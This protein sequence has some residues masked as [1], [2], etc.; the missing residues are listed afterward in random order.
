MLKIKHGFVGQR[1]VV[2]PFNIIENALNNPL[3]SDLA[4]HSI[5]YFPKA[6]NHF[7]SRKNGCGEYLLIYCIKGEG[8]YSL[9]GK[10]HIV[11]ANCFFILPAEQAHEYG[12]SDHAPWYIYWIHFRGRKAELISTLL[13]EKKIIETGKNSRIND[14]ITFFE[15][16]ITALELGIDENIINYVNLSLNHLL[17]TFL[18]NQSY[19]D[20]KARKKGKQNTFF[21][22]LATHY[23][24]EN[25]YNKLTLKD[26]SSY[27]GCSESHFSRLFIK[28]I[29]Y[30]PMNYF[31]LLK[32]KRAC[33]LLKDTDMKIN[34]ISFKLGFEDPYYF[35]R[36]F[37]KIKGMSPK[38]YRNKKRV[39]QSKT[40]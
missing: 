17:S 34:Q 12:A 36:M 19:Q 15:E 14:R 26:I 25:I 30:S 10:K 39:L 13:S 32:I 37:S 21:I 5:G 28:E 20:I 24:N 18:Y 7:I 8:W 33:Q 23:M 3:T 9:Q 31:L 11:P 2:L 29:N 38:N 40:N 35:S 27:F 4:I 6:E 16:I 1:L 22:S